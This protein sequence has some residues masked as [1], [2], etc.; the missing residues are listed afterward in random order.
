MTDTMANPG[1]A[2]PG[3]EAPLVVVSSDCHVSPSLETLRQYCPKDSVGD[4]EDWMES[5]RELREISQKRFVF[6]GDDGDVDI[7][8]IH[9]WNLQTNGAWDIDERLRDLNE[10]GVAA[11]VIFHGSAPFE[12]IPFMATSIGGSIA[13]PELAAVGQ[14][15]YN[16][17]LADFCAKEPERHVGLAY[18]PMWDIEEATKELEWAKSAG[19]RG[20]NFPQVRAEITPYEDEAWER[21]WSVC[22]DLEMPLANHGGGGASTPMTTGPMAL[23]IYSAESNALSRI[24]PVVR[25]V[26]GGIFERHPKLKLIQTEQVGAW[27]AQVLDE[28]DSRWIAFRHQIGDLVPRPPSEYCR[29]NYFVGASFQSRHE[30]ETAILRGCEGNMLWGS[31]YPHPEG[32]YH[33]PEKAGET[34]MTHLAMRNTYA[35]LPGAP[36]RAM[37]GE[38]AVRVYGLDGAKLK[39]VAGRINAPTLEEL[40]HPI[41][42]RPD[43]WGLAFRSSDFYS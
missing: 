22:E 33:Y 3:F 36:V 10:D 32:T 12:P 20:V 41:D 7:Q 30:A 29:E 25:F 14:H 16:L 1:Q 35:G 37:V 23:H 8:K 6:E 28:L 21:F 43:H 24:S 5:T 13:Q 15:M 31:D 42:H 26:L 9:T 17:W 19:L 39:D 2:G 18:L 11:E 27:Y 34:P 40:S 4:F 38:N